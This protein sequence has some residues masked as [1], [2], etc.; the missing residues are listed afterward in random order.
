VSAIEK[1]LTKIAIRNARGEFK[2]DDSVLRD[3]LIATL[4]IVKHMGVAYELFDDLSTDERRTLMDKLYAEITELTEE[5][6]SV[7]ARKGT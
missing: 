7:D 3:A 2:R 4:G 5:L 1:H 6:G